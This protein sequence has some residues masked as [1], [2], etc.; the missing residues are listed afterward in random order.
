MFFLCAMANHHQTTIWDNM[1]VFFQASNKQLQE[2]VKFF[3]G[4]SVLLQ[5]TKLF[6]KLKL[7]WSL[8]TLLIKVAFLLHPPPFRSGILYTTHRIGQHTNP[9][10]QESSCEPCEH[11]IISYR[12]TPSKFNSLP[13]KIMAKEDD[14]FLL[15]QAKGLIF[16]GVILKF[17]GCKSSSKPFY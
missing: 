5:Q 8:L 13:C 9:P 11:A 14:P 1:F 3:L 17:P 12:F 10:P 4:G 16:R 6:D 7:E 15:G 2:K